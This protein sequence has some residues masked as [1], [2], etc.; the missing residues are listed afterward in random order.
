MTVLYKKRPALASICTWV[1]CLGSLLIS[2]I[3]AGVGSTTSLSQF[4]P[5]TYSVLFTKPWSRIFGYSLGLFFG[6]I[7]FEFNKESS[8]EQNKRFGWQV[9][10][11]MENMCIFRRTI[12]IIA[13][14][15]MILLPSLFQWLI[16]VKDTFETENGGTQKT[17]YIL[18]ITLGK[19]IYFAGIIIVVVFCLLNKLKW[20]T[21]VVGN[22][23]WGPLTELSYSAYLVHYFIIVWYYSSL[24]QTLFISIPDLLFTSIAV[25]FTSY[26]YSTPFAFLIEIPSKNLMELILFTMKRYQNAEENEENEAKATNSESKN[27]IGYGTSTSG[28]NQE[29]AFSSNSANLMFMSG[30]IGNDNSK[31]Q[32]LKTD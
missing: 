32:K 16:L 10:N 13:A 15:I 27:K 28:T 25:I 30:V 1:I 8:P 12:F 7:V 17:M 19:P 20:I 29:N 31:P 24:H 2:T 11:W 6:F 23:V 5:Q 22:Y 18:Y 14:F 4:N 26:A 9:I 3:I 21:T